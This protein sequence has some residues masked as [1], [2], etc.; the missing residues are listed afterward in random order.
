MAAAAAGGSALAKTSRKRVLVSNCCEKVLEEH[1]CLTSFFIS[2]A[3]HVPFCFQCLSWQHTHTF[4]SVDNV[5]VVVVEDENDELTDKRRISVTAV[6]VQCVL[7]ASASASAAHR[8]RD[9]K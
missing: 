8:Q 6:V 3:S 7:P 2:L 4:L 1:C 9:S 5:V